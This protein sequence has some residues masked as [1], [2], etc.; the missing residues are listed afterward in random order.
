[1]RQAPPSRPSSQSSTLRRTSWAWLRTA[2]PS[3]PCRRCSSRS[4]P[5]RRPPLSPPRRPRPV[6]RPPG[7]GGRGDWASPAQLWASKELASSNRQLWAARPQPGRPFRRWPGR[8]RMS[9]RRCAR[10]T[11]GSRCGWAWCK[12][13]FSCRTRRPSSSS[14]SRR[15][16]SSCS[17]SSRR[18]WTPATRLSPQTTPTPAR[19]RSRC[20]RSPASRIP[21]HSLSRRPLGLCRRSSSHWATWRRRASAP[22]SSPRRLATPPLAPRA[23]F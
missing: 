18:C 16:C 17:S 23:P 5:R 14:P 7:S 1:M 22:P 13:A 3:R 20:S 10:P 4:L 8:W 9:H 21:S 12:S 6:A 11:G 19:C 15:C 2:S